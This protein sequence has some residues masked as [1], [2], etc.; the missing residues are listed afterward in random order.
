V[1]LPIASFESAQE[2]RPIRTGPD[3]GFKRVA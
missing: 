3:D 2:G 1:V